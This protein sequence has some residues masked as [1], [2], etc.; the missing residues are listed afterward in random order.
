MRFL[1]IGELYVRRGQAEILR[2][3]GVVDGEPNLPRIH[4]AIEAAEAEAQ[5]YLSTRYPTLP[6]APADTPP[7]LKNKVAAL[8]H[9]HLAGSSQVSQALQ[10]DAAEARS[11]LSRVAR[12]I[13][14]LGLEGAPQVDR[15]TAQVLVTQSNTGSVL[16]FDTLKDM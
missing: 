1:D 11:W 7:V 8:A 14:N 12:G 13:A 16:T 15:G 5:S 6:A 10:D 9:R 3:A 2:L 4:A